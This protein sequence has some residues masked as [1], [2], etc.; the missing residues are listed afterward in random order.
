MLCVV[1]ASRY[2]VDEIKRLN[3]VHRAV[4]SINLH[5]RVS[6][7]ASHYSI[8]RSK[9]FDRS[10]N[11]DEYDARDGA[12]DFPRIYVAGRLINVVT[13]PDQLS[14]AQFAPAFKIEGVNLT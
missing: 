3:A 4:L 12:N 5:Q 2:L 7:H 1:T 9:K 8:V 10:A 14:A 6:R 11:G 13:R